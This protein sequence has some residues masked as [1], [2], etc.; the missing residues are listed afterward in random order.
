MHRHKTPSLAVKTLRFR[1]AAAAYAFFLSAGGKRRCV[2]P[3]ANVIGFG[4]LGRVFV[5]RGANA[6]RTRTPAPDRLSSLER[7]CTRRRAADRAAVAPLAQWQAMKAHQLRYVQSPLFSVG[8]GVESIAGQ[9][10]RGRGSSVAGA[11]NKLLQ[12]TVI[13]RHVRACGAHDSASRGR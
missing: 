12:R 8:R 4:A 1:G 9:M 5:F 10:S 11:H 7:R 6:A 2:V 13:P 3:G